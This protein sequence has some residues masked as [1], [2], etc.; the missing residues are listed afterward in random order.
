[1]GATSH[2]S[3]AR[4]GACAVVLLLT[5]GGLAAY[6]SIPD[7]DGTFHG[8][9]KNG[10]GKLRVVDPVKT[11]KLGHCDPVHETP[12]TW[13]Q[14]GQQGDPGATGPSG[15]SGP[16]G[17]TGA[18]GATGPQGPAGASDWGALTQVGTAGP[19]TTISLA[20]SCAS[21]TSPVG[22][23]AN[24][25]FGAAV[26]TPGLIIQ[27]SNMTEDGQGWLGVGVNTTDSTY[28]FTVSVIC[29]ATS[30]AASAHAFKTQLQPHPK[31]TPVTS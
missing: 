8:C 18:T 27:S 28:S 10:T 7:G 26:G 25:N 11:G 19:N 22:G 16:T 14:T 21:G 24:W 29:I 12:V 2:G 4:I 13:N 30:G 17:K 9:Y 1:M 31:L 15:P 6:A 3:R 23:G 5:L 20:P